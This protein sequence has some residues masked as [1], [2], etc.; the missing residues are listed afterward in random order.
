MRIYSKENHA[1]QF[2]LDIEEVPYSLIMHDNFV[3][4][5]DYNGCIHFIDIENK[6]KS[7]YSNKLSH[8]LIF[9]MQQYDIKS[10]LPSILSLITSSRNEYKI[11]IFEIEKEN[12]SSDI[13]SLSF[14][15]KEEMLC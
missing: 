7:E 15:P 1:P 12:I 11:K 8:G 14:Y 4:A 6:N 13:R 2:S 10:T 3:L 5:G 9:Q